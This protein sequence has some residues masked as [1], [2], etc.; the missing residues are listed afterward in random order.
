MAMKPNTGLIGLGGASNNRWALIR[1]SNGRVKK[2]FVGD[3]IEGSTV[4][5]ITANEVRLQKGK[6][7][8]EL[9]MPRG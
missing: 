2:V 5:A 8:V 1:Q 3:R 6:R 4:A 9:A 7:L